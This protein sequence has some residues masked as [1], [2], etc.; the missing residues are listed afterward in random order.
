MMYSLKKQSH[1]LLSIL[2]YISRQA[3]IFLLSGCSFYQFFY[4]NIFCTA[5]K[6]NSRV[7]VVTL[8]IFGPVVL[9]TLPH[10][11]PMI[12]RPSPPNLQPPPVTCNF[13][14]PYNSLQINTLQQSVDTVILTYSMYNIFACILC[15]IS[16]ISGVKAK[17]LLEIAVQYW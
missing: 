14:P 1:Q 16:G 3:L 13:G 15:C 6:N 9:V 4:I 7:K 12:Q 8:P 11:D 5:K 17:I 10:F 2:H